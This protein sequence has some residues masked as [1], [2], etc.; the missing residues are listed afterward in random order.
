MRYFWL[1]ALITL[2]G[3]SCNSPSSPSYGTPEDCTAAGGQCV[4]TAPGNMCGKTGPEN[5]CNCNPTCATGGA[6]CCIEFI[7]AGDGD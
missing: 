5:S 7:E 6:F 2:A 3:F 4:L 1:P